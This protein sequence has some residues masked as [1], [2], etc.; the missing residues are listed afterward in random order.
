MRLKKAPVNLGVFAKVLTLAVFAFGI[1]AMPAR[2][3]QVVISELMYE[4]PGG[5]TFA[6]AEFLELINTGTTAAALGNASFSGITFTFPSGFSLAPQARAVICKNRSLFISRYGTVPGLVDGNYSGS[7]NN[8]GENIQLLAT[9]G[10]VI[11]QV[12]YG[13]DG[14]WPTRPTGKGGSLEIVDPLGAQTDALN[15]RASSEYLGTPGTAGAGPQTRIAINELLAH[16]D[17][18][19]E[20]AVELYNRTDQPVDVGGWYLSNSYGS[21]LKYRIPAGTVIPAHGFK[22]IY[23]YQFN[24]AFLEA[25]R[26]A[27]TFS[28]AYPDIAILISPD[29]QGNPSRFE[30]TVEFPASPNGVSFGRYPDGQGPFLLTSRLSFGMPI[31]NTMDPDFLP[32]FRQGAGATNA[33]HAIGPVVFS[34]FRY[35]APSSGIE[36]IE[37]SNISATNVPLYD[38]AFPTNVWKIEGGVAYQFTNQVTIPVGGRVLVANTGDTAAVRQL[39]SLPQ[40]AVVF[41]PYEGQLSSDGERVTLVRPDPPQMPPREDAGFVPYFIAEQVDYS[42]SAPWPVLVSPASSLIRRITLTVPGYNPLNWVEEAVTP[43]PPAVPGLVAAGILD[44]KLRLTVSGAQS[45]TF[46]VEAVQLSGASTITVGATLA[47]GTL[48]APPGTV[49]S[50]GAVAVTVEI[51]ITNRAELIRLQVN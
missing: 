24:P 34:K 23:E 50:N 43:P 30:D 8:S 14:A 22:V 36:F 48:N 40:D 17:P 10:A 42:A 12:R 4:P 37:L 19:L 18:P 31:D 2:S 38:P 28:A 46:A 41:G 39:L 7:L 5:D 13:V 27:F 1:A 33:P 25:G 49:I 11:A 47:S 3:Q 21:P 6:D 51:P 26:T 20:D 45:K 35:S 15:W 32:I 9:G 16:T 44:G 29:A